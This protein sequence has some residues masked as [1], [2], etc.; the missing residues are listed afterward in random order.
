[1]KICQYDGGKNELI[2]ARKI[3]SNIENQQNLRLNNVSGVSDLPHLS[4]KN[5]KMFQPQCHLY[6]KKKDS[7]SD[8]ALFNTGRAE[9]NSGKSI[10]IGN[11]I[12]NFDDIENPKGECCLVPTFS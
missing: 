10:S 4:S 9:S 2:E 1:M 5:E 3:P 6:M 8:A 12:L 7:A 11:Q